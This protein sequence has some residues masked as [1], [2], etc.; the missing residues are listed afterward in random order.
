MPTAM[1]RLLT[2]R[3]ASALALI[4]LLAAGLRLAL[5][6][7]APAFILAHD[8]EDFFEAGYN[9]ARGDDFNLP[10]KRPPLY[11]GFLAGVIATLGPSLEM[12]TLV[13]HALG[14]GTVVLAYC[15][16]ALAFGRI[17]G[18]VAALGTGVNGSLLL[19]EHTVASE[20][21]YTPILIASLLL[22]LLALRSGRLQLFALAGLALGLGALAR[23]ITQAGLP[24]VL[25]A[26]VLQPRGWRPRLA[27]VGLLCLGYLLI[28]GPWMMR[29]RALYGVATISGGLGDSLFARTNRHD[30]AFDFVDRAE[31]DPD[32][33]QAH[34]RKR[35]F[36]LARTNSSGSAVRGKLHAQ[37]GIN[38]AQSDS[39]LR[40][41]SLQVIRQEPERYVRGTLAMFATLALNFENALDPLWETRVKPKYAEAWPDRIQFA[42]E[43]VVPRPPESRSVVNRVTGFYQDRK[44]PVLLGALFLIG[45]VR[46]LADGRRRGVALLPLIVLSQL[47]LYAAIN[48]Y[49]EGDGLQSRYRY[50]L[51]PL[52]TLVAAGGLAFL[53][54][55]LHARGRPWL[56]AAGRALGSRVPR[57]GDA[58]GPPER[59]RA[60]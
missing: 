22:V 37:F 16:G 3:T 13:Q 45:A 24:L 5:I 28:T 2:P 15:L 31:R 25:A 34:I 53:L 30:R 58:L 10:W 51:Q 6:L 43:P 8:T 27:A 46:C 11:A 38:E 60:D 29:N 57:H 17:I 40:E 14:L 55:E 39:A 1:P 42:M 12:V 41:A 9:L 36:E 19:M 26:I 7:H 44:M 56:T 47:F 4:L 33:R 23:P 48:G 32:P 49:A 52:I 20:G 59:L 54:T 50:P 21:L 18:L 35:I